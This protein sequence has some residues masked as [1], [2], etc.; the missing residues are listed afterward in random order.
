MGKLLNRANSV[1][2]IFN[3]FGDKVK[4]YLD[5]YKNN[6]AKIASDISYSTNP[7]GYAK[8]FSSIWDEYINNLPLREKAYMVIQSPN[9]LELLQ[10]IGDEAMEVF[11]GDD[12]LL[13]HALNNGSYP[14]KFK[15]ILNKYNIPFSH[16]NYYNQMSYE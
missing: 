2:T 5:Y 16:I 4:Q 15:E 9:P 12:N 14:K 6:S 8:M 1:E 3:A 13:L 7:L 11:R 10:L